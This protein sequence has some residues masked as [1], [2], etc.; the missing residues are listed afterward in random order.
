MLLWSDV[1]SCCVGERAGSPGCRGAV[2]VAE[3]RR[4]L[5]AVVSSVC[6][7]LLIVSEGHL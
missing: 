1:S 4:M 5:A 2:C 6:Q 7:K 3:D